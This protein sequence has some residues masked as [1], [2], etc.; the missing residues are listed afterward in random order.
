MESEQNTGKPVVWSVPL[1][2]S[3]VGLVKL[4]T[5]DGEPVRAGT[6]KPVEYKLRY[7]PK[8]GDRLPL[9]AYIEA[10]SANE[11]VARLRDELRGQCEREE[12]IGALSTAE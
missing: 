1:L 6:G 2:T 4:L 9:V 8:F 5:W 12:V 11:A 3:P 10:T 7:I